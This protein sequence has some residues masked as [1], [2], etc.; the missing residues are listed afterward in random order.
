MPKTK[1][2][3]ASNLSG[4]IIKSNVSL[5]DEAQNDFDDIF[6]KYSK[7][8]LPPS[9]NSLVE[10]PASGSPTVRISDRFQKGKPPKPSKKPKPPVRS[11]NTVKSS[12]VGESESVEV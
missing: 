2:S 10:N 8:N 9:R 12:L 4:A 3:N 6:E 11:P 5:L 1:R 7:P